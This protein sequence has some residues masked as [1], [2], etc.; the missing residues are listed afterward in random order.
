VV[1]RESN[2]FV[3]FTPVFWVPRSSSGYCSPAWGLFWAELQEWGPRNAP[4]L[5]FDPI[6][7][8]ED[9]RSK[10]DKFITA[11]YFDARAVFCL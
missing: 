4:T 3:R 11:V 9:K 7:Y 1:V 2:P 5:L 8:C 6:E 10:I